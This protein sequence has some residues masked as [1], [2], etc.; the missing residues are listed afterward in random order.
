MRA[1][2]AGRIL[3]LFLLPCSLAQLHVIGAGF[4]R[5]GT[6]SLREALEILGYPTYHM[7]EVINKNLKYH[8]MLWIDN[9]RNG[10]PMSEI[11][12]DLYTKPRYSAAIDF[13]T[14]AVWKELAAIYPNA[15]II[16]TERE[17]PEV[18]WESASQTILVPGIF[19]QFLNKVSPFF[20][21]HAEMSSYMFMVLFRFNEPR[22]VTLN[23]RD[24]A[25]QSYKRNSE[26][27]RT[28][29]PE[30]ILIFNVRQGWEPLCNF[31]GK[32][33]PSTP[34]PH[35]NTRAEFQMF[36]ATI[37]IALVLLP[38]LFLTMLFYLVRRYLAKQKKKVDKKDN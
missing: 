9:F 26:E 25:I 38:V 1:I 29:D 17:S 12:D 37:S 18:W 27:A 24:A 28:F 10:R 8:V 31:L 22:M 36:V 33:I 15:K 2:A 32:E 13:P 34:F 16:L 20:I 30:R 7:K 19:F 23:D 11:A 5:T 14:C 6:D 3:A 21:K 35:I 4:G